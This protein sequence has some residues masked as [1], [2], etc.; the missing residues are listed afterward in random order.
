M[1]TGTVSQEYNRAAVVR[2]GRRLEYL[3]IIWNALEALIS[4]GAGI[5]AGSIALV[6]FG[7]D[8]II[9]VSSGAVLLW[10]LVSGEHRESS[11]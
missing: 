2:Q 6:G 5:I 4:I 9:E 10:R 7:I 11:P 8:S 3:T 1:S